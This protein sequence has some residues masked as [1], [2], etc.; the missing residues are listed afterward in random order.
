[1]SYWLERPLQANTYAGTGG[2]E[3]TA[4]MAGQIRPRAWGGTVDAPIRQVTPMLIDPVARIYDAGGRVVTLYESGDPTNIPYAG[5]VSDL[6]SGSWPLGTYRTNHARGL[7]QLHTAPTGTLTVDVIGGG[8]ATAAGIAR[9]MLAAVQLPSEF[10]DEASFMGLAA[11]AP[12]LCGWW[13]GGEAEA[14]AAV[15]FVLA[16]VGARLVTTRTGRLRTVALRAL[17]AGTRPAATYTAAEIGSLV[18]VDLGAPLSPAPAAWQVGWGYNHTVQAETDLD[19]DVGTVA[20]RA[21]GQAWRQA[22]SAN[23]EVLA[24]TRRPSRPALVETAHLTEAGAQVLANQLRDLWSL[25]RPRRAYRMELPAEIAS[26]HEIG[27]ALV[28]A[29]PVGDLDAGR[30]CQVVGDAMQAGGETGTITILV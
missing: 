10:V 5:D 11:A 22:G 17:P 1:I 26:R 14:A 25:P 16:S 8:D 19:P 28:V 24:T 6:Y 2:Y 30:L 4:D 7:F 12:Y 15:N 29:F 18:P 21:L 20:A 13:W 23:P 9:A 27:D 3:G